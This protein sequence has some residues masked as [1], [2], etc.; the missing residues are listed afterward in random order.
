DWERDL[1]IFSRTAFDT[2]DYASG[3]INHGSKAILM[4]LGDAKR[5]LA[6][7]FRGELP[8]E[9]QAAEPFCDGCLV[10][11]AVPY[12]DGKELA[13]KLA[14]SGVFDDWQMVVLHDRVEYARST[15]KFLWATWTRFDPASDI[16]AREMT[17][18]NNHIGYDAP[19]FID[20]R[21]KP[22]YPAEVEPAGETVKLV[23]DRWREYFSA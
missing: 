18:R 12:A 17:T 8:A 13:A 22:W 5:D 16:Y 20:A 19:I 10:V 6:R 11:E 1:F 23:D 15:D 3:K 9:V 21:M 7:E 14:R 2:L 4:G